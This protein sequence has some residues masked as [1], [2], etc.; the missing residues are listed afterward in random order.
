MANKVDL[1]I[2]CKFTQTWLSLSSAT[3]HHFLK[4]SSF[5]K[6]KKKNLHMNFHQAVYTGITLVAN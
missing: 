1:A 5:K 2:K 6:K 3:D 4:R